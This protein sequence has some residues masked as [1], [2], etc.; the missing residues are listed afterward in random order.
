MIHPTDIFTLTDFK[1]NST[2]L[3]GKLQSSG[4]PQVLTVEGLPKVVV[5]GVEAFERMAAMA[6]RAETVELIRRG[7]ADVKAARTTPATE[8]FEELRRKFDVPRNE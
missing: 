7:L 5:M 2:E 3:I 6:E 8:V 4:R 1:R